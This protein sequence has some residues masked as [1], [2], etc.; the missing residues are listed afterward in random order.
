MSGTCRFVA[1]I[2]C[3]LGAGCGRPAGPAPGT[4]A[5]AT[6]APQPGAA[7]VLTFWHIMNYTGPREVIAAAVQR[8][9]Q[10]NPGVTVRIETFDNDAYK[11]KLAVEMA[12]GTPPDVFFTWGGG[13]LAELAAAGR[14]V[15]L[16]PALAEHG[17]GERI[18][19][20]ALR[21]CTVNDRT[22]AVPLD[23][24]CVVLWYNTALFAQ[25]NLTPPATIEELLTL[26]ARVKAAG[27]APFALGN[28]QQWPGAFYF[29]YAALRQGGAQLFFDAA[30]RRPG[31]GFDAP[32]FVEAGRLLRQ[33]AQAGFFPTGCNG[34]DD[35]QARVQFLSGKAAMYLTGT[36]L[37]ARIKTEAPDFLDQLHCLPF[38]AAPNGRGDPATVVGGVNCGFAVSAA[39]RV[40]DTAVALLRVLTDAETVQAWCG[41]GRIPALQADESALAQ[42]PAP[43]RKALDHLVASPALQPYYDQ[44]LPP[45]LAEMHKKTTQ[46]LIAGTLTPEQA[47]RRMEECA[48][49][50]GK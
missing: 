2:A 49:E 16:T 14:V 36:W 41:A 47:A 46:E 9:E 11:T 17:W 30:A 18:L 13:G 22:Y 1:L 15:D 38:P 12:G 21:L 33:F 3:V 50:D 20:A 35:N 44:Y 24:S 32:A 10:A 45:R 43:T 29:V 25:H 8:F 40:P 31:A 19:P 42:L 5:T 26:G 27:M 37:V 6:A 28:M 39:C 34:I 23:L 48:R 7:T 4:A